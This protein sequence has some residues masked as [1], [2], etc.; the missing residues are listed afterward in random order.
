M[1]RDVLAVIDDHLGILGA[2][3]RLLS[4]LGYDAELYASA[5][6]FLDVAT[7]T[8]AIGLIIDIQIG[9]SSGIDLVLHVAKRGFAIPVIFM[10]SDHNESVKRQATEIGCI[11]FLDKPF[12]ADMLIEA[13]AK[14]PRRRQW[15]DSVRRPV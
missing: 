9:E 2:M 12:S 3:G 15:S 14:L 8:E 13:L 1:K 11:A 10:S 4:A 6:E 7:M 5:K